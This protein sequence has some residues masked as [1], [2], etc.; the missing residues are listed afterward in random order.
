MKTLL[1]SHK[2][3]LIK[4]E[5]LIACLTRF[6]CRPCHTRFY[7]TTKKSDNLKNFSPIITYLNRDT[8]K[9]PILKDY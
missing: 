2:I 1:F 4:G 9:I 8:H 3:L 5:F 7:S 6:N